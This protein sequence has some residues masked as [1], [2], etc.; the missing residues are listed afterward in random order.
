MAEP[1][2]FISRNRILDGR[3]SE[4]EAAFAAAVGMIGSNKPRTALFAAYLDEAG[5]EVRVVHAFPDPEAMA[6][7][8]EGSE[9]RS[10]SASA[11]I[12]PAGFEVFGPAPS[13]AV[14]Q[15]RHEAEI[16][17]IGVDVFDNAIGGFLRSP[18]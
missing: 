8:F 14:Y 11:L 10:A 6:A 3:R 17:G 7:H 12:T 5:T 4:F 15:L 9:D 2:I 16:A 18:V 13:A 1:I